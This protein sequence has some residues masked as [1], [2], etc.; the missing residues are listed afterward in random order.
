MALRAAPHPYRAPGLN[1]TGSGPCVEWTGSRN[2]QGYGF[3][4]RSLA[5][6]LAWET[7]HGPITPGLFVL[8]HCDNPPCVKTDPDER[9]PDGHLFL[10]TQK[11]NMADAAAKG[12]TFR[13]GPG[14]ADMALRA[15]LAEAEVEQ[16]RLLY[17]PRGAF[18]SRRLARQ[19]GV[20]PKTI[21]NI[22]RGR[23]WAR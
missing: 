15:K 6:R 7:V 11:D 8:H 19:F 3:R 10:G 12:R 16:I 9:Y 1:L 17:T 18:D 4:G 2:R 14:R 5:H 23:S 21:L 20:Q 22:V 13:G